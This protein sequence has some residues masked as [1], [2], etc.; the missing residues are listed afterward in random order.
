MVPYL[1]DFCCTNHVDR[2]LLKSPRF[3]EL[4]LKYTGITRDRKKIRSPKPFT[5][6]EMKTL[7]SNIHKD[8]FD[9]LVSLIDHLSTQ[10]GKHTCLEPYRE[11]LSEISRN[12]PACDLLQL[13]NNREVVNSLQKL[14][15]NSIN[16]QDTSSHC[17]LRL[18]KRMFHS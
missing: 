15:Q 12:S 8:D 7:C 2:V 4:L 16:I 11:F 6:S 10:T 17:E 3:R 14:A 9:S 13:G 1:V 18:F 5:Q